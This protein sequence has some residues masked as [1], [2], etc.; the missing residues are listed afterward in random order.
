MNDSEANETVQRSP[1]RAAGLV[2]SLRLGGR[3]TKLRSGARGLTMRS[4]LADRAPAR[5]GSFAK[6]FGWFIRARG[7]SG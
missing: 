1:A 5:V 3:D 6:N 7:E 4:D 2:A